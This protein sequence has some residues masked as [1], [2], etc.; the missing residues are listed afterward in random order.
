MGVKGFSLVKQCLCIFAHFLP[1]I[2]VTMP[3][4]LASYLIGNV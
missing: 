4:A 3:C 2:P 1:F